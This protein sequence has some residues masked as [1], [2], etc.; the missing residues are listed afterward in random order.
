ME[1]DPHNTKTD[2]VL[3]AKP[4]SITLTAQEEIAMSCKKSP[5]NVIIFIELTQVVSQRIPEDA[6]TAISAV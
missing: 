2:L 6:R 5:I 1:A 4:F 3:T